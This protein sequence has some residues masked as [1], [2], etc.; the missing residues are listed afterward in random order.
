[1]I[2]QPG[3]RQVVARR[4]G[5]G[6]GENPLTFTSG[7]TRT[8]DTVTN[9]LITGRAG[10]QTIVGGTAANDNLT[11]QSTSNAT[12]GLV[13]IS[14]P[15]RLPTL[16]T[17]AAPALFIGAT[18]DKVG[19]FAQSNLLAVGVNG[20]EICYF[21]ASGLVAG[22][23]FFSSAAGGAGNPSFNVNNIGGLYPLATGVGIAATGVGLLALTKTATPFQFVAPAPTVANNTAS[24]EFV[25]FDADMSRT[26]TWATGPV[27]TQREALFRAPTYAFVLPSTITTAAT[28][29]ISGSPSAGTNATITRSLA[30]WV[31]AGSAQFDGGLVSQTLVGGLT[32]GVGLTLQSNTTG[33]KVGVTCADTFGVGRSPGTIGGPPQFAVA[34]NVSVASS[35]GATLDYAIFNTS[36]ITITGATNITTAAGFNYITIQ[37][38]A[39]SGTVNVGAGGAVPAAATL[40]IAS[41]PL[42][43]GGGAFAGTIGACA[44]VVATGT[45]Y[46]GGQLFVQAA[47][48]LNSLTIQGS[49]SAWFSTGMTIDIGANSLQFVNAGATLVVAGAV[50]IGNGLQL[51]NPLVLNSDTAL[52]GTGAAVTLPN[53]GGAGRP[54]AGTPA[55]WW[56]IKQSGNDRYVPFWGP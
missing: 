24:T 4:L 27:A 37:G 35:A 15:L 29:A 18:A 38:P 47:A 8:G 42:L 30:L 31:Q 53:F 2:R 34:G 56:H 26:S 48:N 49:T 13:V 5:A 51:T 21:A 36:T 32:A 52:N 55:G 39:Y 54:V 11:L 22:V 45:T 28:L 41:Q 46:L 16:G 3:L 20:V 17:L 10:G 44:I 33:T 23:P 6:S 9:D 12:R 25:A 50:S 14:D 19:L 40:Y 7:L 43:S 1:M